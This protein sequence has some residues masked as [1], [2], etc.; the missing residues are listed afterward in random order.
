MI[1]HPWFRVEPWA[2]HETELNLEVLAQTESLFA[3]E[4]CNA[5]SVHVLALQSYLH[6]G[7]AIGIHGATP[8]SQ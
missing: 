7:A 5:G 8:C 3:L 1:Q 6:D 4:T 2:L